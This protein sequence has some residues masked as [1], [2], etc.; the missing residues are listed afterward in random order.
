MTELYKIINTLIVTFSS[1]LVIVNW[2][3][4]MGIGAFL[5]ARYI[6]SMRDYI[7]KYKECESLGANTIKIDQEK[8]AIHS[9]Y[10]RD[11]WLHFGFALLSV[12]TLGL[13]LFNSVENADERLIKA[14]IAEPGYGIF[15]VFLM[16]SV[17]VFVVIFSHTK[18]DTFSLIDRADKKLQRS[19]DIVNMSVEER[20]SLMKELETKGVNILSEDE[21]KELLAIQEKFLR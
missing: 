15:L 12:V 19:I 5:S 7:I 16:L 17:L 1:A 4:A 9:K 14:L 18:I 6:N 10:K 11:V 21:S 8:I 13:F 20:K 2:R 3:N